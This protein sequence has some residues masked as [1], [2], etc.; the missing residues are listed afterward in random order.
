MILFMDGMG[1]YSTSEIDKKYTVVN[2]GSSSNATWGIAAEGRFA[3]ALKRVGTGQGFGSSGYVEYAPLMTQSGPWTPNASGVL[4]FAFKIDN[5][6]LLSNAIGNYHHNALITI[7]EGSGPVLYVS[8][9]PQ[10]TF[11]VYRHRALFSG[12][13]AVPLA[14]SAQGVR[15]NIY[16]F[17]EVKWTIAV[18]GEVIIHVNGVEILNYQGD[19]TA[20]SYAHAYTNVWNTCRWLHQG[21]TGTVNMWMCD[22]YLADQ[23]GSG[24]EV[25]DFVGDMTIDY[26]V[27]DGVGAA[28][29][30]TPNPVVANWS[31][32]EEVP[33][34]CGTTY[35]STITVGN[36]DSYS[37]Q[38]VPPGTVPI[39]FQTLG[40]MQKATAGGASV[41]FSYREGGVYYD[42]DDQGIV[43]VADCRY[44][45]QPY[46]TNPATSATITEAEINAAEFGVQKTI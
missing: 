2:T 29:T 46:D 44:L 33:P 12:D 24:D 41:L 20:S 17:I 38:N 8:L 4:G 30:W 3:N 36:R 39:A 37:M 32:V 19:T 10:G 27:P 34:D 35:N 45:I 9:N 31:N 22:S 40:Y 42:S 16:Y 7:I 28:S 1:H 15:D 21:N 11:T 26:I 14:V 23:A 25:R 13:G 18:A 43:T 5:L 6:A